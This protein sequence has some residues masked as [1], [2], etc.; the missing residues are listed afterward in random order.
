M[1]GVIIIRFFLQIF[2]DD[3]SA[4][5]TEN[6]DN[7]EA[8]EPISQHDADTGVAPYF[9]HEANLPVFLPRPSGNMVKI[10]CPAAGKH[11]LK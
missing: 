10:K 5:T 7:D 4:T 11:Q 1:D 2:K 9:M 3:S 8:S 6:Q